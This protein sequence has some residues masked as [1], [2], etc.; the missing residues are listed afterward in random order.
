MNDK[1]Y[2]ARRSWMDDVL[3]ASRNDIAD[4]FLRLKDIGMRAGNNFALHLKFMKMM[5]Q[6]AFEREKERDIIH[7][8]EQMEKRH[9]LMRQC[10]RLRRAG[11]QPRR[12]PPRLVQIEEKPA[13]RKSLWGLIGLLYVL[14]QK[15]I[16]HKNQSLTVD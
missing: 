8:I 12:D 10:N 2:N 9:R 5:E 7:E 3:R 13:K 16:N 4:L 1:L 11:D 14:S 15:P 6:V